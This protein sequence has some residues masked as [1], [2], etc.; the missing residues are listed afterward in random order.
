MVRGDAPHRDGAA[1]RVT[2]RNW[3]AA[4]WAWFRVHIGFLTELPLHTT[5]IRPNGK[6]AKGITDGGTPADVC[7]VTLP[8]ILPLTRWAG[9]DDSSDGPPV[10]NLTGRTFTHRALHGNRFTRAPLSG[11]AGSTPEWQRRLRAG[12][13]HRP[14]GSHRLAIRSAS[15]NREFLRVV[16][17]SF[18]TAV[19]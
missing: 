12:N 1:P 11:C 9:M 18:I 6:P 4:V 14:R 3:L 7:K 19:P 15:A 17:R 13:G 5:N 10:P 2:G 8:F 16:D